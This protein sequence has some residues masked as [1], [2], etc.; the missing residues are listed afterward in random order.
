MTWLADL[1]L[2][3]KLAIYMAAA[4][5][6]VCSVLLVQMLRRWRRQ[7]TVRQPGDGLWLAEN[8]HYAMWFAGLMALT[9][10]WSGSTWR[11]IAAALAVIGAIMI[12]S[13]EFANRRMR[14]NQA[15][16]VAN[17]HPALEPSSSCSV[18]INWSN[19]ARMAVLLIPALIIYVGMIFA[20][21]WTG[22]AAGYSSLAY[23]S[24]AVIWLSGAPALIKFARWPFHIRQSHTL[25]IDAS[26]QCVWDTLHCRETDDY[27]RGHATRIEKLPGEGSRFVW[28]YCDVGPCEHCGLSRGK[29]NTPTSSR[30]LVE[31]TEQEPGRRASQVATFPPELSAIHRL[32]R[33][34]VNSFRIV[35]HAD[36]AQITYEI[37]IAGARLWMFA[38]TW[39]GNIPRDLLEDLKAH[40][41][42]TKSHGVFGA[43]RDHLEIAAAAP[44]LCGCR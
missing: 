40:L 29:H 39:S 38:L 3:H 14:L 6:A 9:D 19:E 23:A 11:E 35:P 17:P 21:I 4:M 22:K 42:G 2:L 20:I 41:E 28:H 27:Y 34:E 43:A 15:K 16:A 37:D 26:P 7:L 25:V 12:A 18:P 32:Y 13:S 33:S 1:S 8:A 24:L 44:H 30:I 10:G 36:G 5:L 31:V